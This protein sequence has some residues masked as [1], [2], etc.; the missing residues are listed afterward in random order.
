MYKPIIINLGFTLALLLIIAVGSIK[1][2]LSP[3]IMHIKVGQTEVITAPAATTI[4]GMQLRAEAWKKYPEY[5]IG[6]GIIAFISFAGACN[7][8]RVMYLLRDSENVEST[9]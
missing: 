2:I 4:A 8:C 5:N 3:T 1:L 7:I 9:T 6:L